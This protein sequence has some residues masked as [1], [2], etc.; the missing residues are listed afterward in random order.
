MY[1]M[2]D[3]SGQLGMP[4]VCMQR[5]YLRASASTRSCTA[6]ET[7]PPLTRYL[8]QALAASLNR[9]DLGSSLSSSLTLA[10][11]LPPGSG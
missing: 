2:P 3:G 5:A 4:W 8:W 11:A 1:P 10:S 9:G 6:G 7:A